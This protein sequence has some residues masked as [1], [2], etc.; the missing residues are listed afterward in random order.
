MEPTQGSQIHRNAAWR[1][2]WI[3][4]RELNARET[5]RREETGDQDNDASAVATDGGSALRM[6][7]DEKGHRQMRP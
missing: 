4:I 5:D 2:F 1:A 3:K 6:T 7:T